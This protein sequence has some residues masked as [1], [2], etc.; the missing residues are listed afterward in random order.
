MK[1]QMLL[2]IGAA[3]A[4]GGTQAKADDIAV[5]EAI[6]AES[7]VSCHGRAGRG[8][9]SFPSIT[10][11]DADYIAKR[12]EQYRA[13]ERVGPNTPLMAPHAADLSDDDIANLAAYISETFQ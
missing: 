1:R 2:I 11:R 6:Y 9:A 10:G 3:L 4:L 5:G 13:G 7:C 8:M 12:L